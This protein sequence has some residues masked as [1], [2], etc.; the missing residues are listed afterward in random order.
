MAGAVLSAKTDQFVPNWY[1][2][3]RPDTTPMAKAIAKTFSQ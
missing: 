2:I 1:D 3:T